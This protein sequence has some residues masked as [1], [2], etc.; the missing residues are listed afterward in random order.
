MTS[1]RN[2]SKALPYGPI[3]WPSQFALGSAVQRKPRKDGTPPPYRFLGTVCGAYRNPVTGEPGAVVS[4]FAETGCIQVFPDYMLEQVSSA[5]SQDA[6]DWAE[7]V[8]GDV[9]EAMRTEDRSKF[10]T[11]DEFRKHRT[12]NHR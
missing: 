11:L 7:S 6:I 3:E 1:M 10:R 9:R 12:R 5:V 8:A 2:G 4:S